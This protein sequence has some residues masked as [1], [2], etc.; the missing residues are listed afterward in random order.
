MKHVEHLI[1]SYNKQEVGTLHLGEKGKIHFVYSDSWLQHGFNISPFDLKMDNSLQSPK[2]NT[3]SGLHGV[4]ADSISDGWGLLLTDRAL[5][6]KFG[7]DKYSITQLDRLYFMGSRSMGGLEY[8]PSD[9]IDDKPETFNIAHIFN[10]TQK[11]LSGEKE[12]II[13][14]LYLSGGSPGGARPKAVFARKGDAFVTGYSSI[15][16]EYEGWIIKFFSSIDS[17]SMG[18]IEKAYANMAEDCG[19]TMPK[20]ELIDVMIDNQLQ[21]FFAIERFDRHQ[22]QRVHVASLSG[23]VYA[24]HRVPSVSYRDIFAVTRELTKNYSQLL[25][26]LDVMLF[27]IIMHNQD[28]HSK[29]FSY[30]YINNQW[31]LTP[32]YDL[33][34]SMG[35]GNEHMSD[36]GGNGNPTFKDVVQLAKQFDL[37]DVENRVEKI[38]DVASHWKNYAKQYDI[39][40]KEAQDIDKSL[41]NTISHFN[42]KKTP[43][44]KLK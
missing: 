10:E 12:D 30:Q 38:I 11:I 33:V 44:V 9:K 39:P 40:T 41:K 24:S 14:E 42:Y 18:K 17:V 36:V 34:Y 21:S 20:T 31:Q 25:K 15:P 19:I 8:S 2:E 4:F 7:W 27:N 35:P 13:K 5:Q 16:K 22:G 28:D 37:K 1:V 43:K 29:N 6:K 23:L 3:F 26:L 32:S